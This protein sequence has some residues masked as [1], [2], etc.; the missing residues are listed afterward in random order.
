MIKRIIYTFI[1]AC[2]YYSKLKD[3][4]HINQITDLNPTFCTQHH[5]R[6]L[7]LDFD[8]VLAS[9]GKEQ[10]N[11]PI[12]KWL[13]D[14][15]QYNPN[16][17]VCIYS[18]KPNHTRITYFKT[19]FPNMPVIIANKKKP[20][21]D[22]FHAIQK[23]YGTPLQYNEIALVDDRLLTGVLGCLIIGAIPIHI[24]KPF[25]DYQYAPWRERFFNFLRKTENFFFY[26]N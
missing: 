18:N 20:Y 4:I 10:P 16:L 12:I 7:A 8:G 26:R 5:I 9:H 3:V 23:Y 25:T 6:V 1:Q 2:R 13:T 21:P 17:H 14:V 19:H 24:S 11:P 22:G 15:T